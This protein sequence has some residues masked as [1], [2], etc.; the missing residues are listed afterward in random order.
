MYSCSITFGSPGVSSFS[1]YSY[2]FFGLS[3]IVTLCALCD[4]A[5]SQLAQRFN[6]TGKA[7]AWASLATS[8]VDRGNFASGVGTP[9]LLHRKY[10]SSL[11]LSSL[12]SPAGCFG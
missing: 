11:L 1:Y 4:S 2:N 3:T 12:L 5:G 8:S 6:T 10:S 9:I 7:T